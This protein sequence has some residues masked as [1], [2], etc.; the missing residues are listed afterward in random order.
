MRATEAEHVWSLV[1]VANY[2]KMNRQD[3]VAAYPASGSYNS[4]DSEERSVGTQNR[5]FQHHH[6]MHDPG[7]ARQCHAADSPC[8]HRVN[9]AIC[10][11]DKLNLKQLLLQ[12]GAHDREPVHGVGSTQGTCVNKL[13]LT[14]RALLVIVKQLCV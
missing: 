7:D 1:Q 12:L 2:P 13:R 3:E 11:A 8:L 5:S 14:P 9:E 6:Q 4:S 10:R